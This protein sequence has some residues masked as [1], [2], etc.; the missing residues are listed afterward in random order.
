M[1]S[2]QFYT[3]TRSI[4]DPNSIPT[5]STKQS[6]NKT[7]GFPV[8]HQSIF[9][10]LYEYTV[11]VCVEIDFKYQRQQGL[12]VKSHTDASF[13]AHLNSRSYY[14]ITH[15]FPSG[16]QARVS[17]NPPLDVEVALAVATQVDGARCDVDVHQV[18][19][20]SALDVVEDAVHQVAP[21]HVH[22][23]NVGQIPGARESNEASAIVRRSFN[24]L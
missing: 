19:D 11:S 18:V 3:P 2:L 24:L 10:V 16:R 17:S 1:S 7:G 4:C 6:A 14:T 12:L 8:I 20:D 5:F 21:A 22:D 13:T 15:L 23:L 9:T